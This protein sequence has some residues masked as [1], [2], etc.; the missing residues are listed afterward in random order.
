MPIGPDLFALGRAHMQAANAMILVGAALG[1]LSVLAGLLSRRV[2]APV[3]LV[4]LV[5]GMLAGADGPGGIVYDDFAS[6]YLVGSV[7]LAVILFE[8]GLKT[9]VAMLRLALWPA[10]VLA[11]IGVGITAAIVGA[12]VAWIAA[13]P[14]AMAMLVGAAVAP[15]DAAAVATLLVR[16]R[17]ALPERVTALLEV[18]SGLNDPMSIFLTVFVIHVIV[19]PG[20]ATWLNGAL[21]FAREMV[22]G[23]LLGLGGGWLLA[24]LLRR[25]TLEAPTAMVLVLAFGLALF[26]LA[27]VLG[28][29]GF[30]AIYLAGV[31]IGATP[32]HARREIGNFVE[33]CAWLA[34]IVLFLMLGLLVTPFRLVHFVPIGI[35]IAVVL[36]VVA[37][38]VATFACLLPFRF[39]WRESAFASWVGLR[40]AVPIYLS[41]LPALGDP[42]RDERLF[43]G[44]FVVVVVSLVIQGW[45][46][47]PVARLLGF[48]RAD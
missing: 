5:L 48:G 47:G 45:T 26:G 20:W 33:G 2:N 11:V 43:S 44:V 12:A 10:L 29:S 27:Q 28:T 18:E 31:L 16:A 23:G 38:P 34:Q 36:I 4:F 6:A 25:L 40:G 21:L 35:L 8:G 7:A 41:F 24:L 46:I 9:H 22:G 39:P 32:H 13:V 42:L 15:T 17:I 19:Q 30:L 37:R 1:V 14:F 3:L